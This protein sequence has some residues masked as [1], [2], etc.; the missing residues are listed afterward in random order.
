MNTLS[1]KNATPAQLNLWNLVNG[2][3][4]WTTITP[5]FYCGALAGSEFITYDAAH[6]YLYFEMVPGGVSNNGNIPGLLLYDM[7]NAVMS[8]V[9]A[10]AGYWDGAAA[11]YSGQSILLT[12]GYFSRIVASAYTTFKFNGYRLHT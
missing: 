2:L 12:N 5:I 4:A 10:P 9:G 11:K 6:L 7:A 3:I 8:S 1:W